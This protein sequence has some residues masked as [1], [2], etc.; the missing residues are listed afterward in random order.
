M[1]SYQSHLFSSPLG[2]NGGPGEDFPFGS[3]DGHIFPQQV[4]SAFIIENEEQTTQVWPQVILDYMRH[5]L[6]FRGRTKKST[7]KGC[8]T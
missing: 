3:R 1:D 7:K 5:Q 6:R 2:A 8:T 4:E